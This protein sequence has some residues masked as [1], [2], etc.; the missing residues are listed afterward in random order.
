MASAKVKVIPLARTLAEPLSAVQAFAR[1]L[2]VAQ[3]TPRTWRTASIPIWYG[4][5]GLQED[6]DRI[7]TALDAEHGRGVAP[8]PVDRARD[9]CHQASHELSILTDRIDGAWTGRWQTAIG[10]SGQFQ[11]LPAL[12]EACNRLLDTLERLVASVDAIS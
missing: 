7:L 1:R 3:W 12:T 9:A 8:V 4:L 5:P 10:G 11:A 6:L 2:A